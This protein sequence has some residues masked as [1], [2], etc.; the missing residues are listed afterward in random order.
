[1]KERK[2]QRRRVGQD[3]EEKKRASRRRRGRLRCNDVDKRQCDVCEKRNE[4]RTSKM[5][6]Y[7][8]NE[9]DTLTVNFVSFNH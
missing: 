5:E 9:K 3:E 7:C 6:V 1:M 2:R 8:M 4:R